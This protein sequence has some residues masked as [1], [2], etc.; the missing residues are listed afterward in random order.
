MWTDWNNERAVR[1]IVNNVHEPH[2]T[3]DSKDDGEVLR[4]VMPDASDDRIE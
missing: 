1:E 4:H 3:P 2:R